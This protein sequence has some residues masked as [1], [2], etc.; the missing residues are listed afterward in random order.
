MHLITSYAPP[1][2]L[3]PCLIVSTLFTD[4]LKETAI[5]F[6]EALNSDHALEEVYQDKK[7]N[8]YLKRSEFIP[9]KQHKTLN[10]AINYHIK[11]AKTF[12]NGC[13]EKIWNR[14]WKP[15]LKIYNKFCPSKLKY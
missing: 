15:Y 3:K 10:S 12:R 8:S 6:V 4:K 1:S 7:N 11:L 13:G 5:C 2:F 14:S 9:I